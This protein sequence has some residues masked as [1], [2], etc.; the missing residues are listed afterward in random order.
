[1]AR[2]LF[3]SFEGIDG[4]GKTTQTR[5]LADYCAANGIPYIITREPGGE[6]LAEALRGLL[7]QQQD[8]QWESESEL[9]LFLAARMQHVRRVILPALQTGKWVICDRFLDSSRVYQT[10]A[11]GLPQSLYDTLHRMVLGTFAPDVTFLL[12]ISAKEGLK[13]AAAR[14]VAADHFE[15]QG[16]TFYEKLRAG[17]LSLAATEPQRIITL[18]ATLPSAEIHAHIVE[19]LKVTQHPDFISL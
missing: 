13:R 1:M 18:D 16:L 3:I 6:P 2:G 19:N 9:L 15:S 12:D 11:K 10:L 14:Q 17:F 4:C 7:L 5:L 8:I